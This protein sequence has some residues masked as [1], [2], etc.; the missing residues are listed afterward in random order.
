[1]E[2]GTQNGCKKHYAC[3]KLL[4]MCC[5]SVCVFRVVAAWQAPRQ[6]VV[7][8][9]GALPGP[10]GWTRTL[11]T[12]QTRL[13]QSSLARSADLIRLLSSSAIIFLINPSFLYCWLYYKCNFLNKAHVCGQVSHLDSTICIHLYFIPFS[14]APIFMSV[15][16][17]LFLISYFLSLA[18]IFSLSHFSGLIYTYVGPIWGLA[19]KKSECFFLPALYDLHYLCCV[20]RCPWWIVLNGW[21]CIWIASHV[22]SLCSQ[23][24]AWP[25]VPQLVSKYTN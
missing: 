9:K 8:P 2:S 23:W 4:G 13:S 24:A 19:A 22:C 5:M 16:M 6:V 15:S 21:W 14:S 18:S 1:M 7:S 20:G 17:T 10:A 12:L 3:V 11:L 25:E